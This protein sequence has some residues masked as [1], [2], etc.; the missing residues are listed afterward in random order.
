[1]T[2]MFHQRNENIFHENKKMKKKEREA[3][4][5]SNCI[6]HF[7]SCFILKGMFP[8]GVRSISNEFSLKLHINSLQILLLTYT[9]N[10]KWEHTC[11]SC[12]TL[13]LATCKAFYVLDQ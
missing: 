4:L 8:P 1:M 6:L 10:N 2:L 5:S 7:C 3:R 12:F 11:N 13:I 9:P